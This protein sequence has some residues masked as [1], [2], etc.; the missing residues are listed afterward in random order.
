MTT[1][2]LHST[3]LHCSHAEYM[4]IVHATYEYTLHCHS[5]LASSVSLLKNC[6]L[7]AQ[8]LS[9]DEHSELLGTKTS[10]ISNNIY[11]CTQYVTVAG[12]VSTKVPSM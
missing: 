2:M 5:K 1:T 4:Y 11:P 6:M 3:T 10:E 7:S 9:W 8:L 12:E